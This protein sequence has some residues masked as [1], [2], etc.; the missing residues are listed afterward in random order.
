MLATIRYEIP[1]SSLEVDERLS[2][3]NTHKLVKI[4]GDGINHVMYMKEKVLITYVFFVSKPY[5]ANSSI[6]ASR[7]PNKK[8]QLSRIFYS[9]YFPISFRLRCFLIFFVLPLFLLP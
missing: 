5:L 2:I 9:H 4:E 1:T 8:K 7:G 3:D 6:F